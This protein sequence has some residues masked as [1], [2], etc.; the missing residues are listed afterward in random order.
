MRSYFREILLCLAPVA[1]CFSGMV[2]AQEPAQPTAPSHS[3]AAESSSTKTN[4]AK[5]S[6]DFLVRGT[7]FTQEGWSLPGAELRIRKTSDKKPHWGTLTNSRGNFAV[8]VKMGSDYEVT[9]RAKGYQ[10]QSVA[11]DTKTGERFKDLVFR[12]QHLG[13]KKS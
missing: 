8:R 6:N 9:V 4:S 5:H 7:V 1:V 12:M 3:P 11:V 13:G 2:L 10:D